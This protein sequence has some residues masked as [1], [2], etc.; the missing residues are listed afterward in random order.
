MLSCA[1]RYFSWLNMILIVL[2]KVGCVCDMLA[3]MKLLCI[4][5]WPTEVEKID[6]LRLEIALRM[7]KSP[8][9]NARMNSLK[10][11]SMI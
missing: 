3:T 8:H 2:Q 9:F 6:E 10:E 5:M 4:H 11:V 7:L 1:K